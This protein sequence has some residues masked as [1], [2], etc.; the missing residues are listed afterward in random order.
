LAADIASGRGEPIR[1]LVTGAEHRVG[2]VLPNG[3]EFTQNKVGRGCSTSSGAVV[4]KLEY[5]YAQWCDL[6]SNQNGVIR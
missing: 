5:S 1:H 4:L 3:F 6:H 2:I